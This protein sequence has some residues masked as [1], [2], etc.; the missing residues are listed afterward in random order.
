V[1]E[2]RY[3]G[4][5]RHALL[6]FLVACTPDTFATDAA[7]DGACTAPSYCE[8]PQRDGNYDNVVIH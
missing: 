1:C 4:A 5:M 6:V 3:D 8:Q 2:S 7:T